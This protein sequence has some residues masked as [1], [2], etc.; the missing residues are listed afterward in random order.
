MIKKKL[1]FRI[2]GQKIVLSKQVK[3]LGILID[4]NLSWIEH[5]SLLN[6]KVS[7][8]SGLLAKIRHYVS[9]K[10]LKPIYS[11]LFHS[12]IL[13]GCQ[14]WG[15]GKN[16]ILNTIAKNQEKAVRTISFKD[17]TDPV[18]PLFKS[19][20]ILPLYDQIKF[21]NLSLTYDFLSENYPPILDNCLIKLHD[22]HSHGTRSARS[23]KLLLPHIQTVRYRNQSML[24]AHTFYKYITTCHDN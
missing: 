24:A 2:S 16:K 11:A 15:Q 21:N 3:Y 5:L 23:N 13:Y 10:T 9:L 20:N 8:A 12:H 17:R 1:N 4:E 22:L 14:I 6:L 7:R 19:L 18:A